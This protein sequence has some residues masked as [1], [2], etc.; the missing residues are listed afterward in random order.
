[1]LEA[2][3]IDQRQLLIV[4][5]RTKELFPMS[6][7]FSPAAISVEVKVV[8]IEDARGHVSMPFRW[9][10]N[11]ARTFPNIAASF[12]HAPGKFSVRMFWHSGPQSAKRNSLD[13]I[14]LRIGALDHD[15]RIRSQDAHKDFGHRLN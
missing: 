1:L 15:L 5:T 3:A 14:D 11:K 12:H 2:A 13:Y 10:L 4:E 8:A 7:Q 6:A 9:G